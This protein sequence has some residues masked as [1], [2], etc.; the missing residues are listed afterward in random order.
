M[1]IGGKIEF[2]MQPCAVWFSTRLGKAIGSGVGESGSEAGGVTCGDRFDGSI[3]RAYIREIPGELR[4][5]RRRVV[6]F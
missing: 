6:V 3:G 2:E 4:L 5:S 1:L